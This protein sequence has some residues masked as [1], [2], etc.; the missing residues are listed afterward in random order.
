MSRVSAALAVA[1][2][3]TGLTGVALLAP[4]PKAFTPKP[5]VGENMPM[6]RANFRYQQRMEPDGTLPDNHIQRALDARN[7]VMMRGPKSPVTWSYLGPRNFGGR[8]RAILIHPINPNIMWV[9]SC[10]GGI[11][12][13]FDAGASWAPL[14][15]FM[16]GMTIGCMV[17][18]PTNPNILYAGTGEGFFETEEGTTNTACIRG[19][20]IFK[21][22]NGGTTWSQLPATIGPDF[23]FVNRLA[24]SPADP[25]VLLAA[26]STGMYRSANGG[27]SWA[28]TLANEWV[29]DVDFHPTNANLAVAGVHSNGVFTTVN[30]G[31]SWTRSPSITAHRSEVSYARSNPQIVYVAA[32]DADAIRIWRSTDGGASFTRQAAAAVSNYAAYNVALWVNPTN[33]ASLL[34]GGVYMY[35]STDSGASRTQAFNNVHPDMHVFA[36]HPG[37]NGTTNKTIFIGNDGGLDRLPDFS[38][39]S[40][41]FYQGIGITQFYGTAINPISGRVMGGTQDNYTLLYSGNPSNWTVTAGGDGGYNQTDLTDQN[42]FYGCVYWAYQFRS[43]NGGVS[44]DY[45]YG[46]SNPITDAGNSS[47]CNFINPFTLDPNTPTRMLVGSLRLWRSN[48]VKS[49]QPSWFVIKPSIAP[50]GRIGGGNAHFAPNNPYDISAVTVAKGNS[51]VIW[52]GHNNGNVYMTTNGTAASPTWNRVDTSG[53]LPDRWVSKIAIDPTNSG[54]VYVSFLGWHDDSVWETT[55]GGNTWT[56]IA[57]GKLIPASVNVI[58]LHPT[59]KGWLFAGTD[60]GLFTSTNNGATWTTTTQGPN[61]VPIEDIAFKDA[62]TLTLATYGRGMWMGTLTAAGV[63]SITSLNPPS[64]VVG[65]GA[66]NLIVNGTNFTPASVVKWAGADRP[67]TF[68]SD[69]Q[70]QA[71]IGA[72]DLA[73]AQ[74]VSVQVVTPPPGGGSSNV[75]NFAINNPVPILT[76]LSPNTKVAGGQA[77]TLTLS[78]SKF[79]GAS[80]VLWNGQQRNSIYVNANTLTATITAADIATPGT[81]PVIVRNPSPGGGDSS[82]MTVTVR[83][84]V[85]ERI[86]VSPK[87]VT[88]GQASNGAVYLNGQA[89]TGGLVITLTKIGSSL[90][91]PATC[92]A[93]AG[94]YTGL[95]LVSTVPVAADEPCTVL[96]SANGT[97]VSTPITVMAPR[98]NL[99]TLDPSSINAG[100]SSTGT[101]TLNGI[102]P[103][104]GINVTLKSGVPTIVQVP[105]TVFVPAG[106][107]GG[108][109]TVTTRPYSQSADVAV[110]ALY[111]GRGTFA[112]LHLNP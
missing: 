94:K 109:F 80:K 59:I 103:P 108:T 97:T 90:S 17:L 95:F 1:C 62:A 10:S 104:G 55:N 22:T 105:P 64:G 52:V 86:V 44:A 75:V 79:V 6:A 85:P 27:A 12:K 45:I 23:Y 34:Y 71:A 43:T 30:G 83:Q 11:W 99:V 29:Y 73:F 15:D 68:V 58:A 48:N 8:I 111:Q 92:T 65:G 66:M 33:P 93:A 91:V 98:P 40:N 61:A 31:L 67:T 60:L 4:H 9:G 7:S 49:A 69:T 25:N 81:F 89:P 14:D 46:G 102:A 112:I 63:P 106:Q 2:F 96:A 110:W 107:F 77:F 72:A 36:T 76:G 50:P 16:P 87:L 78:G 57:S 35:R 70:I 32:A 42:F 3:A 82:A 26:T 19:A 51:D 28:R 74:V 39:S 5:K 54:H 56:D 101:F 88:G 37:F 41:A 100:Q 47:T 24:V 20:G 13:T 84:L 38:G 18:D 53:P 21:S